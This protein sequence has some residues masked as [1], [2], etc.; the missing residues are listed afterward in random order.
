MLFDLRARSE[1]KL[2]VVKTSRGR[3]EESYPSTLTTLFI[4]RRATRQ[5]QL[6][7]VKGRMAAPA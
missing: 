7:P 1:K 3:L 6:D 4:E 5:E 2:V